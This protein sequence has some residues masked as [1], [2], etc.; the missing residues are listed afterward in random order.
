MYINLCYRSRKIT[1]LY[2]HPF[3]PIP[4]IFT[5]T[6]CV[7]KF[8]CMCSYAYI[9]HSKIMLKIRAQEHNQRCKSLGVLKHILKCETY[10]NRKK[11]FLNEFKNI[12]LPLKLTELQKETEFH[13]LHYSILQKNFRNVY[14]R[15]RSEAFYI[16]MF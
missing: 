15:F 2:S 3:K 14:D 16:R 7:Y 12:L 4:N 1:Q 5:T 9:G 11:H 8:Q 6:N 10:K 13:R